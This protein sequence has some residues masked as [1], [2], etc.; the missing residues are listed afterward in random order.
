M[1]NSLTR[2][3]RQV[4]IITSCLLIVL[5]ACAT[6]VAQQPVQNKHKPDS[7]SSEPQETNQWKYLLD[8][9]ATDARSLFP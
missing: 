4:W 6:V 8:S 5:I 1:N 2:W 3:A 9:L 7:V